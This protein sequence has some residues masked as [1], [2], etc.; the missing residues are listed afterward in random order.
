MNRTAHIVLFTATFAVYLVM[1]LWS[2]P[3]IAEGAGGLIPFDLRPSGYSF[4]DARTFLAA[5]DADTIGFYRTVQHRLDA[6]YPALLAASLSAGLLWAWREIPRWIVVGFIL[7][8]VIGAAAD[9]FEN[10]MVSAMLAAG[11]DALTPEVVAKANTATIAKAA[12]TTLATVALL[13]GVL[14]RTWRRL[15]SNRR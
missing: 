6:V 3:R 1:I 13:L 9:Y 12:L 5:L 15:R 2:L 4:E 14:R 11:A 7:I 10:A 8:A